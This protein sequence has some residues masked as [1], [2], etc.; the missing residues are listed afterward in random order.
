MD[1]YGQIA[2]ELAI[3]RNQA[4]TAARLLDEGNTVPFIARYRKEKT[5]C[6]SDG[7]LRDL[8]ER[9]NAL[10]RLEKRRQE[11][12]AALDK[13]SG[14]TPELLTAVSSAATITE[15]EELYA[16]YKQKR[17]T[18]AGIARDKG[19]APLAQIIYGQDQHTDPWQV[20][21]DYVNADLS[22]AD[23][24]AALSGAQDIIAQ[25]IAE[26][27]KV[28]ESLR[29]WM[30]SNAYI[31]CSVAQD[32]SGQYQSY[33]DFRQPAAKI[34]P[35]RLLA[36][37]RGEKEG[38]LKVT[39]EMDWG[40]ALFRVTEHTVKPGFSPCGE[41]VRQAAADALKRLL[42]PSLTR[43]L[44]GN[45]LDQAAQQ[46]IRVFSLNLKPLLLQPPVKGRVIMGLDPA[47]RTGCK[48]AVVDETGEVLAVDVIYP[49]PPRKEI[50]RAEGI[51]RDLIFRYNVSVIAI[52]NGTAGKEAEIFVANLLRD[53]R[54][55]VQYAVVSEAG[56]SVY[57]ASSLAARE[58][59]QYDVS[60]RS[61]ISIA[62]RLQD[63]LAELV[64]IDPK[65]VGVGQYQHDMP[66][67]RLDEALNGVVEDCV[68]SVGV[69]V[70]TASQSLL[71]YVSGIGPAL[72]QNI[73]AYRQQYG[74]FRN[75]RQLLQ[76]PKLGKRAFEQAA[77]FLRVPKSEEPL[78]D[79]AVHPESYAAAKRLLAL[80][81]YASGDVG[82]AALN[83]LPLKV[84]ELGEERVAQGIGVGL[85]TLRDMIRELMQPGRDP[86]EDLPQ[87]Q[88]RADILTLEDLKPGMIVEGVVRNVVDF[89]V[90]VDIGVHQDG[91]V[92]ISNISSSFIQHPSQVLQVGD[93]IKVQ[94]LE[95]DVA[96]KRIA[97][98]MRLDHPQQGQ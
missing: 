74:G 42:Y 16:P 85:P 83:C 34:A 70:N 94:V 15:L 67:K 66:A 98:T 2:T 12:I 68:N 82:K 18:R 23:V 80:C 31:Q 65:S 91:L 5:G 89:G 36:I 40:E 10:R 54:K 88:L 6:L 97:L 78:D 37:C 22:V 8:A 20:A 61:A 77:G 28:R 13:L 79:T 60:L 30:Q 32:E 4:E 43:E 87:P 59:P 1:I 21:A 58:F 90:F 93:Q 69:D 50:A 56:A 47:Y 39:V 9:L 44:R 62:R 64:K 14:V 38:A 81:G 35:H 24:E 17:P 19:L 25:Q 46:S 72:A 29:R 71:A 26:D 33:Y 41:L 75:L 86:R 52:G 27:G 49:T 84:K 51:M 7:Q 11:I 76:V 73:V 53:L 57:S 3:G 45:L 55:P 92:H 48:L 63:P 96:R 95:V